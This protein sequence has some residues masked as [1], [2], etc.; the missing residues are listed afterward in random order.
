MIWIS[1]TRAAGLG[2]I[3]GIGGAAYLYAALASPVTVPASAST[4]VSTAAPVVVYRD[5]TPPA[6]LEGQECV[7]HVVTTVPA[8]AAPAARPPAIVRAAA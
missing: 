4:P 6:V 5:C 3:A 7:T 2:V 1:R 8:P